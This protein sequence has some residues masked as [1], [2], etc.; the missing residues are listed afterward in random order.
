[1][2]VLFTASPEKTIFLAMVPLAWALRT[3]GHEVRFAGSP[4]FTGTITQ[5]GLTAVPVGR[6]HDPT[7][8]L[9]AAGVTPEI[10]EETRAGLGAPWD[11]VEDAADA[12]WD[13]LL[14]GY[15]EAV[16]YAFKPVNFPLI[17]GLV[18]FAR[19][20]EPDLVVWDS[21]TYAGPIA[22]KACGAAHARLLWSVDVFGATRERFLALK[23]EQPPPRR[24]DPLADWLGG[25]GRKYGFEFTE[26]MTT[27]NFTIDQLPAC[28][29]LETG[30]DLHPVR[31][32]PY[33]G[34]ATVPKWLWA[35]PERPRIALTF[36]TTATD[37]FAG[38]A[39]DVQAILEA[40]SDLP[41]EVVATIA[42]AEQEKLTSVP[43]NARL[44]PYVPLH[45]LAPTCAAAIHHGGFGT[46]NT[47]ALHAVPQLVL[48]YHFDE[49]VFAD[50]YTAQGAG[51]GIHAGEATGGRV[52]DA[53]LRLLTEPAF[54]ERA[55]VL[56]DEMHAMASPNE[57]V[58][59]LEK[60][61][62]QHRAE[63]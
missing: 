43:D 37:Q 53:V 23:A 56:R 11:V 1:M 5:A 55:V 13:H 63:G 47:F 30:L 10:L 31:Y 29:R 57:L 3:A 20:W 50:R 28:L 15:R 17:A 41:V 33:G 48:P 18:D 6:D 12:R 21:L 7:R 26:D 24:E 54:R 2:R 49:P 51:L 14:Q 60:A 44:L 34:A 59:R 9:A 27:G 38:Y 16:D 39:L 19:S 42:E 35:P 62:A 45:V 22:A 46:L 25:Y 52:R 8:R 61:T 32:V 58:P 4:S 36:G 40:L